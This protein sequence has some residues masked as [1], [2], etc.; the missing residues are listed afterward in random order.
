MNI[1]NYY[2]SSGGGKDPKYTALLAYANSQG[3]A[4]PTTAALSALNTLFSR[5]TTANKWGKTKLEYVL[6][7]YTGGV[8]DSGKAFS[9]INIINPG[10]FNLVEV[11]APVYTEKFGWKSNGTTS[12]LRTGLNLLTDAGVIYSQ[13]DISTACYLNDSPNTDVIP[14]GCETAGNSYYHNLA[15]SSNLEIARSNQAS[16]GANI[17]LADLKGY[18]EMSRSSSG[19]AKTYF[20]GL[21]S[22]TNAV[23]SVTIPSKELYVLASNDAAVVE[24]FC[25][26]NMGFFRLGSADVGNELWEAAVWAEY[27]SVISNL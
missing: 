17:P 21:N 24:G 12:C 25:T 10:T 2:Y 6:S 20:N 11:N 13:N 14:Y 15:K 5:Y 19:A 4:L 26:S 3:Y 7:T 16:S 9:K 22:L 8:G 18:W 27:F 1:K 23:A